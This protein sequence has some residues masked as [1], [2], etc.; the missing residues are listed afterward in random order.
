MHEVRKFVSDSIAFNIFFN[1]PFR[2]HE[3]AFIR[4]GVRPLQGDKLVSVDVLRKCLPQLR[5]LI[6]AGLPLA[7]T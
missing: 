6:M 5:Q 7:P 3:D 2:L 4:S 1:I